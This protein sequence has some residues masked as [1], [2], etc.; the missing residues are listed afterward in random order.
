MA[1]LNT[2]KPNKCLCPPYV[3]LEYPQ[4]FW[5]ELPQK[6][7]EKE[8]LYCQ[9]R[10][11]GKNKSDSYRAAYDTSSISDKSVWEKSCRLDKKRN[12]RAR[13][14]QLH[15]EV[16]RGVVASALDVVKTLTDIMTDHNTKAADRIRCAEL[17]GR[18]YKLWTAAEDDKPKDN[19]VAK[20]KIQV[21]NSKED[22]D[23]ALKEAEKRQ[24]EGKV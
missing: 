11:M 16:I 10:V 3:Q 1:N 17:I 21:V 19:F 2:L 24:K 15:A 8:E 9:N 14:R 5:D 18:Y 7:T 22:A 12:V 20:L 23:D 13:M 4:S 6:L